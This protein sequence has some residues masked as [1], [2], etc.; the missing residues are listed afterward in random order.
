MPETGIGLFPDVGAT[1]F[2]N[3]CPGH[4]GRYLGMTGA[5]L[6]AADAVYCGFATHFVARNRVAQMVAALAESFDAGV[7]DSYSIDSGPAPLAALQPAI[8]GCFAG[9]SVEGILDALAAEVAGDDVY[10][11]WAEEIRASLL[12]KSPTSL[13]ITL[14]QLTIGRD[15]DLEAALAL[16]Y[17]LTQ[18]VMA[19]HDFY[20]GIRAAL[21]DR[22]RKPQWRPA[23][24]DEVSDN[25]ID[26]Y[27]AP[28][29]DLELLLSQPS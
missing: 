4:I 6:N 8:D 29:G 1:R 9:D 13:K 11:G 12:A 23:T 14:R 28:I 17:R 24:L 10:A 7:L 18:H 21:I 15:Y 22:D 3:R 16:E 2:L 19:A 26:A 27:F 25:M 20:E 5:R